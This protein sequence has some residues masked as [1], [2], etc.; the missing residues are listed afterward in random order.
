MSVIEMKNKNI[1]I[2]GASFGIG[3]SLAIDLSKN[4]TICLSARSED[5]LKDLVN[6]LDKSREHFY[7]TL[8]VNSDESLYVAYN[9]V[10]SK[11]GKIDV[12]IYLS[13][14]YSPGSLIQVELPKALD[15]VNTNLI[16][17]IRVVKKVLNPMIADNCGHIV[18]FGSA[19]AY[20]GLPNSSYYGI[21][22]AG[23]LYFAESLKLDLYAS[24]I[25]VQVVNPGFVKTRLTD[26]NKFKMPFLITPQQASQYI[27]NGLNRDVFDIHFP[28]KFTLIF[29][30]LRLLPYT[31]YFWLVSKLKQD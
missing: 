11:F 25:K 31:A 29:K 22:K 30:I 5:K 27:V 26:Q 13:A 3:E 23:I 18:L 1:W 15:I 8:D 21:S 12:L 14:V 19:S 28:K 10:I 7:E 17:A 2:V 20:G 4:N 16:G 9:N 24:N 6:N